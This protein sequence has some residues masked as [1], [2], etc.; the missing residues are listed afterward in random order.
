MLT[1]VRPQPGPHTLPVIVALQLEKP[2]RGGR[3]EASERWIAEIVRDG[4]VSS[5]SYSGS[6]EIGETGTKSTTD[7]T[8]YWAVAG[9][10]EEA[11]KMARSCWS[12]RVT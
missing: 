1:L 3:M 10:K 5:R 9:T 12:R 7:G 2:E 8:V 4:E 11:E 6:L